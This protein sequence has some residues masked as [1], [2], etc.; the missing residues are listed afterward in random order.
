LLVHV[1]KPSQE[2]KFFG[3]DEGVILFADVA[4]DGFYIVLRIINLMIE[5]VNG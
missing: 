5:T 3:P 2:A 4:F 1:L